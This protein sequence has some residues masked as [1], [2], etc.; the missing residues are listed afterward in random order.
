[1]SEKDCLSELYREVEAARAMLYAGQ[2]AQLFKDWLNEVEAH[3]NDYQQ[4]LQGIEAG[5]SCREAWAD[6]ETDLDD[7]CQGL[8]ELECPDAIADLYYDAERND[9]QAPSEFAREVLDGYAD[10]LDGHL[11]TI[12]QGLAKLLERATYWR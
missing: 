8:R 11:R 4:Y 7:F 6:T 10:A 3:L 12:E 1:M 5:M 2:E 9:K